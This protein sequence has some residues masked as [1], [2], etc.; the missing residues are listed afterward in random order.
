MIG[1]NINH[2]LDDNGEFDTSGLVPLLNS[3]INA[4]SGIYTLKGHGGIIMDMDYA[5]QK[6][7]NM[8]EGNLSQKLINGYALNSGIAHL[9]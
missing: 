8:A 4:Y 9:N 7:L 5:K 2:L 6:N 1:I 3:K